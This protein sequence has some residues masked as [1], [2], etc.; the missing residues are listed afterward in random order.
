MGQ[1]QKDDTAIDERYT[2]LA[3]EICDYFNNDAEKISEFIDR[4]KNKNLED[5]NESIKKR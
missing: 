1:N 5:K 2:S 4:L 3:K